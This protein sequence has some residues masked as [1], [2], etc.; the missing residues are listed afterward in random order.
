MKLID[1]IGKIEKYIKDRDQDMDA[2]DED[3]EKTKDLAL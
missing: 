3:A 1:R 2:M